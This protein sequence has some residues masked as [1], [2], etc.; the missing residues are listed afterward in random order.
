M[1]DAATPD[2]SSALTFS[3]TPNFYRS[4]SSLPVVLPNPNITLSSYEEHLFPEALRNMPLL[5]RVLCVFT[6][7]RPDLED[8]WKLLQSDEAFETIRARSCSILVNTITTASVLLA[9]SV[10]FITTG[11]PVP[12]FD[13]T[14]PV[15]YLML[16]MS[17]MLSMIAISTSGLSMIRWQHMDWQLTQEQLKPGG[18][19]VWSYLLSIFTPM[20]FIGLSFNFLIFAM[21]VTGFCSQS[22]VCRTVTALWLITYVVNVGMI[23]MEFLWKHAKSH[24]SR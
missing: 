14:S 11:S 13:Y 1:M 12:F 17:L 19:F 8:D 6:L 10:A 21:L 20:L 4:P 16:L 18:Y 7:G 2:P 15:P 9:T 5:M 23:S 22:M 3:L 24:K